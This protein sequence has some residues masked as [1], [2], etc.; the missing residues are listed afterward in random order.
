MKGSATDKETGAEGCKHRETGWN[1]C[2]LSCKRDYVSKLDGRGESEF[3]VFQDGRTVHRGLS[4][5][6]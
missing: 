6:R 3:I 5:V 4:G 1:H 2:R